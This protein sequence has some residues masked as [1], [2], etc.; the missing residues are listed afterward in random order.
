MWMCAHTFFSR[1]F[2]LDKLLTLLVPSM[3][4][5]CVCVVIF[6]VFVVFVVEGNTHRKFRQES[7]MKTHAIPF[8]HK[9]IS[10][11][12]ID[13]QQVCIVGLF[14]FVCMCVMCKLTC[15][16]SQFNAC[17]YFILSTH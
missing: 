13:G 5:L 2:A 11:S 15:S 3:H 9:N 4:Q 10:V 14:L 6:V 8:V 1:R 7:L 17:F 16:T 12:K